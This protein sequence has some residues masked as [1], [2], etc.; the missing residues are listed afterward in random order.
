[1]LGARLAGKYPRQPNVLPAWEVGL[2]RR[3]K[4]KYAWARQIELAL[5]RTKPALPSLVAIPASGG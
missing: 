3:F 4:R 1:M 5:Y 2:M